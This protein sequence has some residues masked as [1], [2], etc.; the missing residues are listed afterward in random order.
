MSKYVVD[1]WVNPAEPKMWDQLPEVERLI[2]TLS[3]SPIKSLLQQIENPRELMLQL[4]ENAQVDKILLCNWSRPVTG[5]LLPNEKIAEYTRANPD[6]FVGIG[7]VN[8][9]KPMEAVREVEKCVKEFGFKG[10]RILPW[11]WNLP[12]TTNYYYPIYAKCIELDIPIMFQ[13]GHT[14]PLAP[15]DPGRP[16]PYIDQIALDFPELK[17][18]GGHIGYPW[19]D[20]MIS[21]AWKHPNVYIDTSAYA[22]EFYPQQLVHFMNTYG[23]DKVMFGT[24]WPQLM[25]DKCIEQAKQLPLKEKAMENFMWKNVNRVLKLGLMDNAEDKAKSK[26]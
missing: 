12:P 11:L 20:E 10:I 4:M 7:A 2:Q 16:I 13:V 5:L 17:I 23:Q 18:V 15:S 22:P 1:A 21:C 24:N 8:L 9:T 26:I 19:T 25:W 3:K 6:K 14:G